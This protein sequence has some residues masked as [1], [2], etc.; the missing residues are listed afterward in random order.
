MKLVWTEWTHEGRALCPLYQIPA[1]KIHRSIKQVEELLLENPYK[2]G[3]IELP[4]K[5]CIDLQSYKIS[6]GEY[7]ANLIDDE[8]KSEVQKFMLGKLSI[9]RI[10]SFWS[11]CW[12]NYHFRE[13]LLQSPCSCCSEA[14]PSPS[15]WNKWKAQGQWLPSKGVRS[16]LWLWL[17]FWSLPQWE[18]Y[19]SW[20][21]PVCWQVSQYFKWF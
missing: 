3:R 15:H 12:D 13:V 9:S 4:R 21:Q 6:N 14:L 1:M 5:K 20:V 11:L 18:N 17:I 2:L 7:S 8:N 16:I 10:F 19:W